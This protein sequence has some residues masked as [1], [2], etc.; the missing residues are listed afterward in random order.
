MNESEK[1]KK[2]LLDIFDHLS[3]TSQNLMVSNARCMEF[4]EQAI[5][6][7]YGIKDPAEATWILIVGLVILML[8]RLVPW[9]I[10]LVRNM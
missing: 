8:S 4:G 10:K 9:I 2:E 6:K 3:K 7:Q 1:I 5:K